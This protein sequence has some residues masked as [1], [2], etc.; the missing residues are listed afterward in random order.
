MGNGH[1]SMTTMA[2][3][4]ELEGRRKPLFTGS[5]YANLGRRRAAPDRIANTHEMRGGEKKETSGKTN[6]LFFFFL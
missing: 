4:L 5:T 2:I 3:L 1:V 6:Y